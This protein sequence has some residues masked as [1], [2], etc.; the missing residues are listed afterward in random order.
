MTLSF[1]PNHLIDINQENPDFGEDY[2]RGIN[3]DSI[4]EA[5]DATPNSYDPYLNMEL[6]LPHGDDST[7]LSAR[8][9]RRALNK[10]HNPIG[11]AHNNPLLDSRQYDVEYID[12]HLEVL[13]AN[14][15][16]ENLLSQVDQERYHQKMLEEIVE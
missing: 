12:G 5:D 2:N 14:I 3:N 4:R 10:E 11:K 15:I 16:A 13:S 9:K 7:T 8:V 1:H 6:A